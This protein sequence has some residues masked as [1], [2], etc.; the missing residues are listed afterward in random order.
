MDIRISEGQALPRPH[1]HRRR[2][3]PNVSPLQLPQ[4][5]L[6]DPEFGV[7]CIQRFSNLQ[8]PLRR[9]GLYSN[10]T[11]GCTDSICYPPASTFVLTLPNCR[12]QR[13]DTFQK[14]SYAPKSIIKEPADPDDLSDEPLWRTLLHHFCLA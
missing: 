8:P 7:G 9:N 14:N 6:N 2:K 3:R 5:A 10:A 4:D 11:Q 1:L 13:I 12:R